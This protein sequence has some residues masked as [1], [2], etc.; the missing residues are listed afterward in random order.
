MLSASFGIAGPLADEVVQAGEERLAIERH[1]RLR[2]SD[3]AGF[4][5]PFM[6][7]VRLRRREHACLAVTALA[8]GGG[9]TLRGGRF[10][11]GEP[12]HEHGVDDAA[13]RRGHCHCR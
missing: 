12:I 2:R 3:A 9:T 13:V 8:A 1:G 5:V 10:G 4:A 6:L 7:A 11:L